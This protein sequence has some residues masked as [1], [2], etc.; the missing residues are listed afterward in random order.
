MATVSA[1]VLALGILITFMNVIVS[2]VRGRVAGADPW[3]ADSLE[4]LVPSPPPPYNFAE[5]PTVASRAPLWDDPAD[6][7]VVTGLATDQREVLVTT[8]LDAAPDHRTILA[9]PSIWPLAA[10]AVTAVTFVGVMFSPWGLPIGIALGVPVMV[11]WFWPKGRP[12]PLH[13]EQPG[14]KAA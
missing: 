10:A 8:L 7:G 12:T 2:R 4:W 5:I 11:G 3:Q 6:R 1:G 9:G 14:T 13:A